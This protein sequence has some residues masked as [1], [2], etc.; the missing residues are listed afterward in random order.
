MKRIILMMCVALMSVGAFAE[1]NDAWVGVEGRYNLDSHKNVGIGGKVQWEC[2][3]NI[4]LGASAVYY[5]KKND[6]QN[7]DAQ[8]SA[9]YLI[10]LGK[11]NFNFYPMA[12]GAYRYEKYDY[13]SG[14]TVKTDDN[15]AFDVLVGAG[16]E[17]PISDNVKI[18]A[19]CIYYYLDNFTV[20]VGI[21]VKL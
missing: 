2:L 19:E 18:N 20:G 1:K 6:Y 21:S 9:Q 11:E 10:N 14:N 8:L 15:N 17:Y 3:K 7:F 5:M 16:I 12:G 13:T 4:R